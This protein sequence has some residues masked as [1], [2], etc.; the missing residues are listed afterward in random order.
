MKYVVDET[1]E[2]ERLDKYL[3]TMSGL[4][5]NQTQAL[6]R[7]GNAK[8]FGEYVIKPGFQIKLGD[9]IYF[10]LPE[11]ENDKLIGEDIPLDIIYEDKHILVINKPAGI[12]VHP[13]VGNRTGTV[14]NALKFYFE[15]HPDTIPGFARTRL[16]HRLDKDTSG[17]LVIA[18]SDEIQQ[19]LSN[20]WKY[21]N[22]KKL[23]LALV[24]GRVRPPKGEIHAPIGRDPEDRKKMK[25]TEGRPS[26]TLYSVI[27]QVKNPSL[28]F[29]KTRI[30]TGRT[31]QIRVHFASIGYPVIG[32]AKYNPHPAL[33]HVPRQML[34]A[35]CIEFEH[36][37][38]KKRML[39][40]A[41][42]P[43]DMMTVLTK[44]NIEE[45][46]NWYSFSDFS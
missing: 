17:A 44:Y 37:V 2:G 11:P 46:E 31:H 22:V 32:D 33:L 21:R 25:V 18:K 19:Y 9:P 24:E 16:V 36:P 45:H 6:I 12:V 10:S 3:S 15:H 38:S 43:S 13:A 41:P 23:Y 42:V 27:D 7:E 4:T 29:L 8:I 28:T 26:Y 35:A 14:A 34:H 39:I 5:R 30:I 20:Q 40:K 1:H